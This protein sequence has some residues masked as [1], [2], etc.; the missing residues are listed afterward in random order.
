MSTEWDGMITFLGTED[1]EKTHKFYNGV[2]GF[3]LYK[4][5]GLCRIYKVEGGGK[6]AFCSHIKVLAEEKSP[7]LT[8]LT[9]D[10]DKVYED[11]SQAGFDCHKP[12]ENPKFKIYHLFTKDPNGY[13]V[14]VQKFLD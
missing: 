12:K 2:L 9:D 13:S 3:P 8:F 10:V 7:I 1:L 14:E 5:Q 11:L 4:D 6:V